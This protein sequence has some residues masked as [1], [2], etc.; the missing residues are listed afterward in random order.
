M[1]ILHLEPRRY[2]K[3]VRELLASAG[4]VDYLELSSDVELLSALLARPYD[5]VF[6]RLGLSFTAEMMDAAPTVKYLV[7]PTTGLNH[8]DL[9]AAAEWGIQLISLKG[10]TEYLQSIRSTSEHTIA[11]L[12]ALIRRLPTAVRAVESGRWEREPFLGRELS[13]NTLGI[14]GYGRLGRLVARYAQAFY[15]RV[16]VFDTDERQL[17]NLPEGIAKSSL[18]NLLAQSDFVSLHIPGTVENANFMDAG[19]L[20]QMK[21]GAFLINT[22]RGEVVCEEDL[23]KALESGHLGGAA[24]DVLKGDSSWSGRVPE[25]NPLLAFAKR[26]PR[27]IITPHIG[28]YALESLDSTRMF[29]AR[30]FLGVLSVV[31]CLLSVVGW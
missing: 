24:L 12:L 26:D 1:K 19:K 9:E 3:E 22:S 15:M 14:I 17:Q 11:L 8:I 20:A 7:T 16:L 31:G 29:V 25:E 27:L 13:G 4:E 18:E 5:A 21:P 2:G 23:L 10:E 6:L 30:K 28:G